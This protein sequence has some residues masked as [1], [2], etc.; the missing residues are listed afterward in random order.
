MPEPLTIT[1]G[2]FPA[3]QIALAR[4][5]QDFL[6]KVVGIHGVAAAYHDGQP[7]VALLGVTPAPPPLPP[8]P[9]RLTVIVDGVPHAFSLV[10][11]QTA[12]RVDWV[13]TTGNEV[14][15]DG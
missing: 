8:I 3:M 1:L 2:L 9:G 14:V 11:I 6:G 15:V 5:A 10:W 13:V 4:A 7:A 12:P